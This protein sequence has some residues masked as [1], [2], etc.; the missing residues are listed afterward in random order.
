MVIS[1]AMGTT[2]SVGKVFRLSRIADAAWP[3][4]PPGPGGRVACS[5]TSKLKAIQGSWHDFIIEGELC[6]CHM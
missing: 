1:A 2:K 6:S 3:S 4:M 5:S